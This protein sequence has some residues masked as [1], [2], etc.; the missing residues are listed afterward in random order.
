MKQKT[1]KQKKIFLLSEAKRDDRK[2]SHAAGATA[3]S[4]TQRTGMFATGQQWR[5][6]FFCVPSA[7][8]VWNANVKI[9]GDE[10]EE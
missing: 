3:D 8:E 2:V 9:K 5:V 1:K 7:E 4:R 10:G 6:L